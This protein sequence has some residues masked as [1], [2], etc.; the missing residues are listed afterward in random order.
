MTRS[1]SRSL[2]RVNLGFSNWY[3]T[4]ATEYGDSPCVMPVQKH[5]CTKMTFVLSKT[6]SGFPGRSV[7]CSDTD[8]RGH[9]RVD[10]QSFRLHTVA[11]DAP[12]FSDRR[13]GVSL[14]IDSVLAVA[15][16][17]PRFTGLR[18]LF[19]EQYSECQMG[20]NMPISQPTVQ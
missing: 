8:S 7:R 19:L 1:A 3:S 16:N 9:V 10:A 18:V 17:L 2:L 15:T 5:P 13:S 4:S 12:H 14:S 6:R 20:A 11:F